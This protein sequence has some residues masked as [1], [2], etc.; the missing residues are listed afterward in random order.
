ME[1]WSFGLLELLSR[2]VLVARWSHMLLECSA[3]RKCIAPSSHY[4]I[5]PTLHHSVPNHP[6]VAPAVSPPR[7]YL[8]RTTKAIKRGRTLIIEPTAIKL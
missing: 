1:Y 2:A 5:T 4:S 8:P 7:Q 3:I 6:F